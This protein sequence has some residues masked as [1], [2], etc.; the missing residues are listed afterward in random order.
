MKP[1]LLFLPLGGLLAGLLAATFIYTIEQPVYGSK[2]VCRPIRPEGT[3]GDVSHRE[4]L[5]TEAGIL[6]SAANFQRVTRDLNLEHEWKLSGSECVRKLQKT[7]QVSVKPDTSL[8]EI[9]SRGE[10]PETVAAL[11]NA[12]LAAREAQVNDALH[13]DQKLHQYALQGRVTMLTESI[14]A[15]RA[16]L[17]NAAAKEVPAGGATDEWLTTAALAPEI[18]PLRQAW[19]SEQRQLDW[20]RDQLAT[21]MLPA[22]PIRLRSTRTR[23]GLG[24]ACTMGCRPILR[25]SRCTMYS[26]P[27]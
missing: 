2:A 25:A 26:R 5:N 22:M 19:Q 20:A 14:A 16:A 11:V 1:T 8:I 21:A 15:R 6:G 13:Q 17:S 23:Q 24:V 9:S 10:K 4:W 7:I 27:M 18:E 3:P 12:T